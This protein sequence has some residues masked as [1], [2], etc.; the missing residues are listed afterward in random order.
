VG[1]AVAACGGDEREP[2]DAPPIEAPVQTVVRVS[3]DG[4]DD[5]DGF[6]Q[7]VATLRRAIELANQHHEIT[8]IELASGRYEAPPGNTGYSLPANILK[9]AGPSGGGAVLVGAV[10]ELRTS[11][12]VVRGGRIQDLQLDGFGTAIEATGTVSIANVRVVNSS[13]AIRGAANFDHV[14]G[15][16]LKLQ[17]DNLDVSRGE[18][19]MNRCTAGVAIERDGEVTITGFT[20]QAIG[21]AIEGPFD[22]SAPSPTID[23]TG[24]HINAAGDLGACNS[25]VLPLGP[26]VFTL[27]DSVVEGGFFGIDSYD[28]ARVTI[29]GSTLRNQAVGFIGGGVYQLTDTMITGMGSALLVGHGSWSLTGVT[30]ANNGAGLDFSGSQRSGATTL[31]MRN[32]TVSGNRHDGIKIAGAV[33]ADLGTAASPGN[34]VITGNTAVGLDLVA[35][36][37]QPHVT[38]AGNTWNAGIQDADGQGQYIIVGTLTGPMAAKPGN[39]FALATGMSLQR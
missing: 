1:L 27:R 4:S 13:L 10:S 2:P 35:D 28:Q 31:T 21:V 38:A 16:D 26:S 25:A 14:P 24:A 33:E 6:T 30:I 23:V 5:G 8:E 9:I 18:I 32:S 36:A 7:P 3:R 34:N 12:L 11:G 37:D 15:K 17:I 29:V 20:T 22:G 39:N 19:P